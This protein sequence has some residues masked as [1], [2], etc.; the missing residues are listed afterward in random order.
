MITVM[1]E[2]LIQEI[3]VRFFARAE[4]CRKYGISEKD[5]VEGAPIPP[6]W[7]LDPEMDYWMPPTILNL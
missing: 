6:G 4:V 7:T 1:D 3:L 2:E 5:H